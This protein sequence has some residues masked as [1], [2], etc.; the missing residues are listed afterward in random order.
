[1]RIYYTSDNLQSLNQSIRRESKG[2]RNTRCEREGVDHGGFLDFVP[3]PVSFLSTSFLSLL[4]GCF[5]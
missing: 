4:E 3:L 5:S 1:M 2:S